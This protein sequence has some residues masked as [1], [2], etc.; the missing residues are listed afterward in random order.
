[1]LGSFSGHLR[2]ASEWVLRV[3]G[4]RSLLDGD[5]LLRRCVQGDVYEHV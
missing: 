5:G 2:A 3:V 4:T 1:M